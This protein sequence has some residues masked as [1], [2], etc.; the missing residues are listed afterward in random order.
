M[1][2][3]KKVDISLHDLPYNSAASS[4]QQLPSKKQHGTNP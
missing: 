4:N 3:I 1:V 2:V